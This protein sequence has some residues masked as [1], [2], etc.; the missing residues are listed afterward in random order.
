MRRLLLPVLAAAILLV[1]VVPADAKRVG[2]SVRGVAF[3][4]SKPVNVR[5][6]NG[7][8]VRAQARRARAAPSRR[9]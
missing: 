8:I 6:T 9:S 5:L 7:A 3:C 2:M 1:A 4:A